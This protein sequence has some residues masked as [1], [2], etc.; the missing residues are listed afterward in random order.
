[1]N[2]S[3]SDVPPST[4]THSSV[5]LSFHSASNNYIF[6]IFWLFMFLCVYCYLFIFLIFLWFI[7][8]ILGAFV[9]KEKEG[10]LDEIQSEFATGLN[11]CAWVLTCGFCLPFQ[12][13]NFAFYALHIL[14]CN[15]RFPRQCLFFF[16]LFSF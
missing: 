10:Q 8:S 4:N 2:I 16:P 1:M 15:C 3:V 14:Y 5:F 12:L 7:W 11:T 13:L 9:S 6:L